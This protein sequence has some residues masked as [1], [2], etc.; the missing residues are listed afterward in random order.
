MGIKEIEEVSMFDEA[1]SRG[2]TINKPS[3][4]IEEFLKHGQAIA[5]VMQAKT[6]SELMKFSEMALR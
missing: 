4:L 3:A 6:M 5:V 1:M 2:T